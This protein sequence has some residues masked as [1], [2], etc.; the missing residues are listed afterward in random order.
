MRGPVPLQCAGREAASESGAWWRR[1][2]D[3]RCSEGH[4]LVGTHFV[5]CL[6]SLLPPLPLLLAVLLP[7]TLLV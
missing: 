6:C 2:R 5:H 4:A 1:R 7:L 3:K